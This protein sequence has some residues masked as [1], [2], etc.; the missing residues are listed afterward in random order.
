MEQ[1]K[2]ENNQKSNFI[3]SSVSLPK[4]KVIEMEVKN[5]ASSSET[6][7]LAASGLVGVLLDVRYRI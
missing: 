4:E 7:L 3:K 6:S 2:D 5:P 1:R